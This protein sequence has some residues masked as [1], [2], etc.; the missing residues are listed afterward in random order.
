MF[1]R[2]FPRYLNGYFASINVFFALSPFT[3][4]NGGTLLVPASHQK[5]V[6]PSEE[7]LK[8]NAVSVECG[9][10]SM[11][12]FD[13]TLYH[14]AGENHSGKDRFGINHQFTRSFFKQQIDYVRALGD[15]VLLAQKPRTQQLLGW[16]TR[17]PSSLDEYYRSPDERLYRKGQG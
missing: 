1:H 9:A 5:S 7:E 12:I 4:E 2:D 17:L 6:P 10:G 8:A 16:Y 13:S 15:E 14:A 3:R 11:F